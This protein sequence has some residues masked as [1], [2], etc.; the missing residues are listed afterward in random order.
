M[1][2]ISLMVVAIAAAAF[3]SVGAMAQ[4]APPVLPQIRSADGK[5][6]VRAQPIQ[7][8]ND[9]GNVV[10]CGGSG[11]TSGDASAANQTATQALP[12]ANATRATSV[13]GITG[14]L[15]VAVSGRQEN[16]QLVTANT[17]A[18]AVTVYGG[19]Y[20]I[21]QNCSAYGTVTVRYQGPDNVMTAMLIK[22]VADSGGGTLVSLG[23]AQ[24]IDATL[25][26]TTGCSVQLR[27]NPS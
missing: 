25:S 14:G 12:G 9:A 7:C 23:S 18:A 27:R 5:V 2:R 11:G 10:P 22:A 21:T 20:T 13:Q 1:K 3:G 6:V 17:P 4:T 19:S 15:P 26:G 16:F 24:V 8:V